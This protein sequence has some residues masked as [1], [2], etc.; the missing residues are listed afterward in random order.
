MPYVKEFEIA[1]ILGFH[2]KMRQIYNK[3]Q[4]DY[5]NYPRYDSIRKNY[6]SMQEEIED[7]I[8]FKDLFDFRPPKVATAMLMA[9]KLKKKYQHKP[10]LLEEIDNLLRA[11]DIIFDP[12]KKTY[13]YEDI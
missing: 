1:M 11:N 7:M 8:S 13:Y 10:I 5:P 9:E 12:E 2:R 6:E 3:V 4:N